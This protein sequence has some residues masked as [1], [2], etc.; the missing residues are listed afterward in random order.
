GTRGEPAQRR[1]ADQRREAGQ[2]DPQVLA[3]ARH[4]RAGVLRDRDDDDRCAALRPRALRHGG[5]PRL[6]APGR[7]DDRGRPGEQQ[8]GP[9]P[10]PDLR[11]D[12]RAALGARHGRVRQF[13]RHVQQLRDRAGRR[14]RRARRHVPARLS[15]AAGDAHGRDPQDP[16]QDHGRAPG[17]Q[18]RGRAGRERAPHRAG[19]LLGG[20]RAEEGA[21]REAPRG[22]APG[23]GGEV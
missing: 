14:P 13:R 10:A 8:D 4:L 5:L 21:G 16:R 7:P 17:Q 15:A 2:L 3:V 20:V 1:A 22:P 19:A 9:G 23:G 6:A 11:P 18:A 12:A